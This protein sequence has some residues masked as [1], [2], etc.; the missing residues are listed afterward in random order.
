MCRTFSGDISC[1]FKLY[2]SMLCRFNVNLLYQEQYFAKK[3]TLF[4]TGHVER[5]K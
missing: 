4:H 2:A 1:N 3:K 5:I